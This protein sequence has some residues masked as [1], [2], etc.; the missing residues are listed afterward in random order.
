MKKYGKIMIL[1]VISLLLFSGIALM[2]NA[3]GIKN[4][5][6]SAINS[7]SSVTWW[8]GIKGASLKTEYLGHTGNFIVTNNMVIQLSGSTVFY[9][10]LS[11]GSI[12]NSVTLPIVPSNP[13]IGYSNG[14][15]YI[16][17]SRETTSGGGTLFLGGEYFEIN[18][19]YVTSLIKFKSAVTAGPYILVPEYTVENDQLAID[20]SNSSYWHGYISQN[21]TIFAELNG[22]DIIDPVTGLN[23]SIKLPSSVPQWESMWALQPHGPTSQSSVGM[24]WTYNL[25][26]YQGFEDFNGT[27][28]FVTA[29]YEISYSLGATTSVSTGTIYENYTGVSIY[30]LYPANNGYDN[31]SSTFYASL[32]D[33]PLATSYSGQ[34]PLKTEYLNLINYPQSYTINHQPSTSF[35][36]VKKSYTTFLSNPTPAS[37]SNTGTGYIQY[38]SI[39]FNN[40]KIY[41][42]S[43]YLPY[44]PYSF[45]T[46]LTPTTFILNNRFVVVSEF[47]PPYSSSDQYPLTLLTKNIELF[48][49]NILISYSMNSAVSEVYLFNSTTLS[50]T[51]SFKIPAVSN[52]FVAE[53]TWYYVSTSG[54]LYII[55][56][57]QTFNL[58]VNIFGLPQNVHPNISVFN[59]TFNTSFTI[60]ILPGTIPLNISVPSGYIIQNISIS[61]PGLSMLN[62]I[63]GKYKFASNNISLSLNLSADPTLNITFMPKAYVVSFNSNLNQGISWLAHWNLE[64]NVTWQVRIYHGS[65]P[66][67]KII[68]SNYI[69]NSSLSNYTLI[70]NSTTENMTFALFNGTYKYSVFSMTKLFITNDVDENLTVSG[71]N[72]SVQ[73]LFSG[74]YPKAVISFVPSKIPLDT[75]W[76]ISGQNS[77][78]GVGLNITNY[79]WTITGPT[80]Y[81]LSGQSNVVYF[82]Q[83]GNYTISLTVYNQYGLKNTTTLTTE[84]IKFT[85]SN[86]ISI[87]V[88]LKGVF[89]N[90]SADYQIEVK[91]PKNMSIASVE[92]LIDNSTSMNIKF[93]NASVTGNYSYYFYLASFNPSSLPYGNHFLNFSAYST[94]GQFNYYHFSKTFGSAS[95]SNFNLIQFFGG[96]ENFWAMIAA[97]IGVLITVASLKI[98]RSTVVEIPTVR[99]GKEYVAEAKLK[100]VKVKTPKNRNG[101]RKI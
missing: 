86:E 7:Q 38:S 19:N 47:T 82:N 73:V 58:N 45:P 6:A 85:V 51:Y 76:V 24:P 66:S 99:N 69:N 12:I 46:N 57:P 33:I 71:S 13:Y 18:S 80:N 67:A 2:G 100:S 1:A 53:S 60:S 87:S 9:Y 8:S 10:N 75:A 84:I 81:I 72:L 65:D 70:Q 17:F 83:V 21:I 25:P 93:V 54:T 3:N 62:S 14:N 4:Q 41:F 34:N 89:T 91:I 97:L 20:Y 23:A 30:Q 40:N 31:Y 48:S 61:G 42:T 78:G 96:P 16:I 43:A 49:D 92:A 32:F 22:F 63:L 27:L 56:L 35:N 101:G 88:S 95:K 52:S 44:P 90:T 37:T 26:L 39:F 74:N 94:S 15:T 29:N 79:S 36:P 64:K 5:T 77:S 55:S 50:L 59:S 98:S 11:T 68:Y 28:Y